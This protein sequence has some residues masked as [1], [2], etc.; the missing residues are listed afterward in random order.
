MDGRGGWRCIWRAAMGLTYTSLL[1]PLLS[2]TLHSACG[3]FTDTLMEEGVALFICPERRMCLLRD[4]VKQW[5]GTGRKV[6][7]GTK[8]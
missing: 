7:L 5:G 6:A 3:W 8:C 1:C 2:V 4:T